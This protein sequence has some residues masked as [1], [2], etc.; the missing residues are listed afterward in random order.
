MRFI[1]IY[2]YLVVISIIA[3]IGS[4]DLFIKLYKGPYNVFISIIFGTLFGLIV[5]YILDKKYIFNFRAKNIQHDVNIFVL[6]TS[7]GLLTT[8]IFWGFEWFFH[9]YF[10]GVRKMRYLGGVFGLVLGYI[11]KYH[12]DKK[13]VFRRN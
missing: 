13:Y 10:N 7:M 1:I 11:I 9:Y 12:L 2:T 6:Y 4:Q 5:K 3:N 8:T